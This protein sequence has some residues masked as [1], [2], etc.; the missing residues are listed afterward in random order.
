MTD[1]CK[2]RVDRFVESL[3]MEDAN[4]GLSLLEGFMEAVQRKSQES[5]IY[6]K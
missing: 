1:N 3:V 4:G 2:L 5:R 6:V